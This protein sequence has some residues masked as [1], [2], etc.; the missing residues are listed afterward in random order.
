MFRLNI[1]PAYPSNFRLVIFRRDLRNKRA[2]VL[3]LADEEDSKSF[4]GDSVWVRVPP[5]APSRNPLNYWGFGIFLF[6][7]LHSL[8]SFYP[9]YR[10]GFWRAFGG[11]FLCLLALLCL[12]FLL[13]E[14]HDGIRRINLRGIIQMRVDV[15]CRTDV[16]VSQ[17]LLNVFQR[18]AVCVYACQGHGRRCLLRCNNRHRRNGQGIRLHPIHILCLHQRLQGVRMGIYE[19][20]YRVR[21]SRS[22]PEEVKQNRSFIS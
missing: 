22:I 2:G 14:S 9:I 16:A 5:P 21:S 15:S 6:L 17:P 7:G 13:K 1:P 3:E 20:Q 11:H 12:F 10:T 4:A 18:N 19:R 8:S